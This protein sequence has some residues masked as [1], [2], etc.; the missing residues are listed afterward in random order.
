VIYRK[1]KLSV[2][3]GRHA[4]DIRPAPNGDTYSYYVPKFYRVVAVL[5]DHA[6]VVRTRRGRRHTLTD[7]DVALRRARW[8][9]RLL[10]AGQ[11]PPPG[12]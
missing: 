4:E 12:A 7:D 3:P 8:W 10:F 5:N 6:I 9:E 2:H 1:S 11:F